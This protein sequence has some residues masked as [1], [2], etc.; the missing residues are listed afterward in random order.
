MPNNFKI[1][2]IGDLM[3]AISFRTTYKVIFLQ[4]NFFSTKR[5]NPVFHRFSIW[6]SFRLKMWQL[7]NWEKSAGFLVENLP[8]VYKTELF[9]ERRWPLKGR[10]GCH[11]PWLAF[12]SCFLG[13]NM[14]SSVYRPPVKSQDLW[15]CADSH[16]HWC[17]LYCQMS[18]AYYWIRTLYYR[19]RS[20]GDNVLGSVRLSVCLPRCVWL[21]SS[22]LEY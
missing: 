21:C 19:P 4:Q 12:T 13:W 18:N 16:I 11:M 2:L 8:Y 3:I 15:H 20:E 9:K 17:L 1:T 6:M 22:N 10:N 5:V 7:S 14:V